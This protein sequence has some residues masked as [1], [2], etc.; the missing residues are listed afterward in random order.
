MAKHPTWHVMHPAF[1][2]APPGPEPMSSDAYI[3]LVSPLH[4]LLVHLAISFLFDVLTP[5]LAAAL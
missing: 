1:P 3:R 2:K 4:Q 5:W